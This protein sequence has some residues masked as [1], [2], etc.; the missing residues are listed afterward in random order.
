MKKLN[1]PNGRNVYKQLAPVNVNDSVLGL[2][3]HNQRKRTKPR[4][5]TASNVDPEPVLT[6]YLRP[7][8]PLTYTIEAKKEPN[9]KNIDSEPSSQ[10]S[11]NDFANECFL[12]LRET[13]DEML[14]PLR[15]EDF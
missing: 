4:K 9:P 8:S 11:L 13:Y 12:N 14:K 2:D 1:I 7:A 5:S 10:K 6:D 15:F 3:S